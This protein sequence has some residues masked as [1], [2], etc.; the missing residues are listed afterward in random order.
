[1]PEIRCR[2]TRYFYTEQN[3]EGIHKVVLLHPF[4]GSS[5]SWQDALPCFDEAFRVLG[6]D[7]RG[8]GNSDKSSTGCTV[9]A[10]AD[11]IRAAING[12]EIQRCSVLAAGA[13][14]SVAI[15]LAARY[16]SLVF[17]LVLIEPSPVMPDS[18]TGEKVAEELTELD[19]DQGA[20]AEFLG[21]HIYPGLAAE[22][23]ARA[24]EIATAADRDCAVALSRSLSRTDLYH[25]LGHITAR[26]LVVI[27]R[28]S[29]EDHRYLARLVNS[30]IRH[31]YLRTLPGGD[32]GLLAA[33]PD[34]V[35]EAALQLLNAWDLVGGQS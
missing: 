27:G 24:A 13:G 7:L 5:A 30:A 29:P 1:M 2:G 25:L 32:R 8:F 20:M 18:E 35:S 28:D 4:L 16:P 15:S 34:G 12:A 9:H 23:L 33:D 14:A 3:P 11:E 17:K 31:S 10:L 26:T 19:W 6:F 21:K 22:G